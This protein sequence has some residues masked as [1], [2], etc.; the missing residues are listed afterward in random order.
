MKTNV[1]LSK[2][3]GPLIFYA[4]AILYKNNIPLDYSFN[5]PQCGQ[6]PLARILAPQAPQAYG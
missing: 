5:A 1:I 3:F 2:N 6:I 4:L